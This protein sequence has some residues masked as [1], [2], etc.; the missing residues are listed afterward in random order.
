MPYL[1]PHVWLLL[2]I[3]GLLLAGALLGIFVDWKDNQ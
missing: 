1:P 3:V 2:Y